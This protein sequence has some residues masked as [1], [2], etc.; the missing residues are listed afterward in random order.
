MGAWI[1]LHMMYASAEAGVIA[2]RKGHGLKPNTAGIEAGYSVA[3]RA[4]V[5]ESGASGWGRAA[6]VIG[7]AGLG[8]AGRG[9]LE[10]GTC[11]NECLACFVVLELLEVVDEHLVALAVHSA[12]SA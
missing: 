5:K 2:L 6:C 11:C 7:Q 1:A 10:F 8:P 9:C 12:G 3:Y 4:G